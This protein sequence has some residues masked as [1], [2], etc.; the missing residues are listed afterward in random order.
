[1]NG[2][3][4]VALVVAGLGSHLGSCEVEVRGDD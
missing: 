1:V 3:N 2:A 4:L